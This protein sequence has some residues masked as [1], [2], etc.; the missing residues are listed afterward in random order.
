MKNKINDLSFEDSI[1]ELDNIVDKIN[2]DSL[3]VNDM[4]ELFERGIMLNKH[5]KSILDNTKGKIYKL[6][7]DNDELKLDELK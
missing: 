4:V 2:G 3:S 6:I 7:K 5:C 1:K